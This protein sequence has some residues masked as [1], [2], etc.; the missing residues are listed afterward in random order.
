MLGKL[1]KNKK[2]RRIKMENKLN[3]PLSLIVMLFTFAIFFFVALMPA[4]ISEAATNAEYVCKIAN[5]FVPSHPR[6]IAMKWLGDELTKRSNGRIKA[7]YYGNGVLGKE[8]ELFQMTATDSVQVYKGGGWE[9]L[10]GRLSL[11]GIPFMFRSYDEIIYFENS[12]FVK[13][14]AKETSHSGIY[15]PA[16]GFTAFRNI[17]TATKVVKDPSDLKG[18][19]MRS[20]GQPTILEFYKICGAIPIE[21]AP[22]DVYMA[23]TMKTIDGGC[24]QSANLYGYKLYEVAKNFTW[25]DYEA[26]VDPLMVS[27]KWYK[28][29]P[30]ELQQ[31]FD[32][33][34]KESVEMSDQLTIQTEKDFSQKMAEQCENVVKVTEDSALVEKWVQAVIPLREKFVKDG[35]FQQTDLDAMDKILK[36]YRAQ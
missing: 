21:M 34:A 16:I 20:P 31:S 19:K 29:L 7:E 13:E 32:Q 17:I 12:D 18:L 33:V 27:M 3:K 23:L 4:T 1:N 35:L 10:S 24:N 11:W 6:A 30:T 28:S 2:K 15:I 9:S 25:I 22:T 14:I 26:G 36:E 5:A 8:R